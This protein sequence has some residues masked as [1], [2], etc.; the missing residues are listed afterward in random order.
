MKNKVRYFCI[1]KKE[2]M[3]RIDNQIV[4]KAAQEIEHLSKILL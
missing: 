1:P 3:T 4:C 2:M